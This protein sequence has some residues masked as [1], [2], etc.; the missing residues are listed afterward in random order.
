MSN[1]QPRSQGLF[2]GLGA[3]R[4][5]GPFPAPP[6]SQGKGPG[7]EVV[8]HADQSATLPSGQP[9]IQSFDCIIFIWENRHEKDE[10]SYA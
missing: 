6:P 1:T 3:G 4:E 2:P 10:D 9:I 5:K 7:N 8:Q